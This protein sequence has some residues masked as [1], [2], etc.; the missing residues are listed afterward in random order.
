V[1][2]PHPLRDG[3]R[4]EGFSKPPITARHIADV[5][6]RPGP[7]HEA[8]VRMRLAQVLEQGPE[9]ARRRPGSEGLRP[10]RARRL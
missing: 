9:P 10:L 4:G 2:D 7:Q 3:S 1:G 8:N 5:P 6:P